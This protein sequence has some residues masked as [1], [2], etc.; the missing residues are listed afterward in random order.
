MLSWRP[1]VV[2]RLRKYV[3]TT[4]LIEHS[5]AEKRRRTQTLPRFFT[6]KNCLIFVHAVLI[7]VAAGWQN[8]NITS[9]ER[10]Q[11][12]LLYEERQIAPP[13]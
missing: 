11:I 13:G 5:F 7:R 2:W 3:R 6:E 1:S 9:T 10:L 12:E 8:I 4:N